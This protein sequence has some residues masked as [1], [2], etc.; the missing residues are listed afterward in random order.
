MAKRNNNILYEDSDMIA[1]DK[2]SGLLS[3]ADRM[4]NE[5]LKDKLEATCG[6]VFTVHRL[7][8]DTS[9]IILFA[10]NK[11]THQ[12][13]SKLFEGRA[14][15]KYYV[16]IVQGK[17]PEQSGILDQPIAEHPTNKGMMYIQR[18]GKPS[19]TGFTVIA[20]TP[21]FSLVSFRLYTGRTHQIRVHSQNAG[22]PIAVDPLYGNGDPILLSRYK[23]NYKLSKKEDEEH[24]ILNRLALHA[25]KL[26]FRKMDGEML[27]IESPIPKN[28]KVLMKQLGA[29]I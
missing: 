3:I 28:F 18:N 27:V 26:V 29:D 20:S 16:A 14:I 2:P 1:I 13:L 15:E 4:G 22:F 8:R 23:K 11:S 7:D 21:Y 5:S 24:P 17:P 12:Y 6:S 10:K 19:Q 9:G 25:H